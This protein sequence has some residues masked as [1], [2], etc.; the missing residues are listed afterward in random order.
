MADLLLLLSW[1]LRLTPMVP[2]KVACAVLVLLVLTIVLDGA[3]R[4]H[5]LPQ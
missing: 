1:L 4:S 2:L 5:C 3:G